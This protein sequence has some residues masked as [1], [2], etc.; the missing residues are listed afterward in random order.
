MKNVY[1]DSSLT[2]YHDGAKAISMS[3]TGIARAIKHS[4]KNFQLL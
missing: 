3:A 1:Y 4:G 2:S